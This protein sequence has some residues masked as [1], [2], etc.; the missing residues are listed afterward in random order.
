M[1]TI[2]YFTEVEIITSESIFLHER[3]KLCRIIHLVEATCINL[4]LQRMR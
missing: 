4:S 1:Y 3:L 2:Q